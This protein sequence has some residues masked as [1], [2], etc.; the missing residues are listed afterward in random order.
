MNTCGMCKGC[1]CDNRF[2]LGS[3]NMRVEHT[4]QL[5]VLSWIEAGEEIRL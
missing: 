5:S 4:H 2:S 1:G 3:L